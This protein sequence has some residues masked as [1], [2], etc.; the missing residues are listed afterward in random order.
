MVSILQ[1]FPKTWVAKTGEVLS[2]MTASI[3]VSS[4]VSYLG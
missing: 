1:G 3:L 2:I 4:I